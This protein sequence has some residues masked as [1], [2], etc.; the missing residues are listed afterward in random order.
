[1]TQAPS[2]PNLNKRPAIIVGALFIYMCVMAYINRETLTVYHDYIRFFSTLGA[3]LVV[4]TLL[5]FFLRK[6]EKLKRE[7]LEDLRRAE[8]ERKA[9]EAKDKNPS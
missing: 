9:L 3:E 1:M 6:R 2:A 5:F 7:R 8:E 4:L